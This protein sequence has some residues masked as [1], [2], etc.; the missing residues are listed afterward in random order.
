MTASNMKTLQ[1][2]LSSFYENI[3][4]TKT[5]GG[6]LTEQAMYNLLLISYYI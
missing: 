4:R 6:L 1:V 2:H 3:T 5:H